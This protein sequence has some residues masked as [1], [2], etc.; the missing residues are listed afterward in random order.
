[1]DCWA[2]LYQQVPSFDEW[3]RCFP[4]SSHWNIQVLE[5]KIEEVTLSSWVIC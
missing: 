2:N 5:N 3:S 1:M 4:L